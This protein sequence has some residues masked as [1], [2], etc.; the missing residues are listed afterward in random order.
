MKCHKLEPAIT[1]C[2]MND[3]FVFNPKYKQNDL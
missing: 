2:P 1:Y 3:S